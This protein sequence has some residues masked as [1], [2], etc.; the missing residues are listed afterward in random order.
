MIIQF[1]LS[2][3][4]CYSEVAIIQFITNSKETSFDN[5]AMGNRFYKCLKYLPIFGSNASGKSSLIKGIS[6][7]K[8]FVKNNKNVGSASNSYCRTNKDNKNKPSTFEIIVAIN[9]VFYQYGFSL[10]LSTG[11]IVEEYLKKITPSTKASQTLFDRNTKTFNIK[12][13]KEILRDVEFRMN[14]ALLKNELFLTNI[15]ILLEK[16]DFSGLDTLKEVYLYITEKI[17]IINDNISSNYFDN[18]DSNFIELL[19]EFD[20][21]IES[22][23]RKRVDWDIVSIG[24]NTQYI[25]DIKNQ[26]FNEQKPVVN[27]ILNNKLFIFEKDDENDIV[28]STIVFKRRF[29]DSEFDYYDESDGT[30]RLID[31]IPILLAKGD[32]SFF[33][34]E[35]E[36]SL[37][38]DIV[39]HFFDKVRELNLN[40]QIMFTT[41]SDVLFDSRYFRRDSLYI[42]EKN[43]QGESYLKRLSQFK[44]IYSETNINSKFLKGVYGGRANIF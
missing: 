40:T 11:L 37:S 6:F 7:F 39:I 28:A 12:D 9:D 18:I 19:E 20:F 41:H 42:V 30:L 2:N 22:I 31:F 34:D 38:S 43:N 35:I 5:D 44:N 36:K 27:Y 1:G 17:I 8:N 32:C 16:N 14:D 29:I 10:I 15:G 4:L 13:N 26:L 3:Y 23:E 21:N 33:I 24:F 25:R